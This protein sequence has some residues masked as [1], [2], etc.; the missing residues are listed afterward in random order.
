MERGNDQS[1]C[2]RRI[3]LCSCVVIYVLWVVQEVFPQSL[4]AWNTRTYYTILEIHRDCWHCFMADYMI[5]TI[6]VQ[7]LTFL[8]LIVTIPLVVFR[9]ARGIRIYVTILFLTI[10]LELMLSLVLTQEYQA[11]G[12]VT[13]M[14]K[15][16]NSLTFFEVKYKCC[17]VLGP[18]DYVVMGGSTP[19]SCYKDSSGKSEDLY[20]T[21]CSTISVQPIKLTVTVV[22]SLICKIIMLIA[23]V[24]Y[25][26]FLNRTGTPMRRWTWLHPAVRRESPS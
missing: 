16:K 14:W 4:T 23:L 20:T 1:S 9:L 24:I 5:V 10:W 18:G 8:L 25:M 11:I 13:R 12:D 15:Y 7:C 21:G 17:G 19:N 2:D 6:G 26:I 22:V 3:L